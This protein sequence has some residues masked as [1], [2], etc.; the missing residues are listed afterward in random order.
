M[1]EQADAV[2]TENDGIITVTFDRQ[3]KL[4][5]I[6]T[7]MS[8]A[9]WEATN[10]L[11]DRD[12]LRCM[13]ITGKG[14]Y[15]TAGIDLMTSVGNRPGNPETEHLHPGWNFRRN[16][17]EPPPPL[18]RIRIHRKADRRGRTRALSRRG[19]RNGGLVR[20]S[21]LHPRHGVRS[22]RGPHRGHL[23]QRGHESPHPPDR[24]LMGQMAGHGRPES[25]QRAGAPDR[26]GAQR[27]RARD[28]PGRGLR[29]LPRHHDHSGGSA[30]DR[31]TRSG[32]V[33]R[34]P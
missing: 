11:A 4:N 26:P 12:D 16:Y 14:T 23:R 1:S 24:S 19:A 7:Q 29:V 30:G 20:L 27:V 28:V 17:P 33:R 18:R 2:I 32:H 9:L 31:Q 5:A 34:R 3:K 21:L 25:G 13:V 8:E 6:N 22:P 10:A 15:F